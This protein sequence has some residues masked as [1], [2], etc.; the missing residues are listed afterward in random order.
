MINSRRTDTGR[1]K[2]TQFVLDVVLWFGSLRRKRT[3]IIP[4]TTPEFKL[5]NPSISV[6]PALEL[7][8]PKPRAI[9]TCRGEMQPENPK[10]PAPLS[11][12]RVL[13]FLR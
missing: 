2:G 10:N 13:M 6:P 7:E 9:Y 4:K 8:K 5:E 3:P 11:T 1:E 12:W